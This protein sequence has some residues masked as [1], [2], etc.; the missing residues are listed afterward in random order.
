M[1]KKQFVP[2]PKSAISTFDDGGPRHIR[3]GTVLGYLTVINAHYVEMGIHPPFVAKSKTKTARLLVDT[4]KFELK[5]D[6]R[7]P[8]FDKTF[9]KMHDL[10]RPGPFTGFRSLVYIA[11]LGHYGGFRQQEYTM[12]H[13]NKAKYFVTPAGQ[14]VL[15]FTMEN[16]LFQDKD[17]MIICDALLRPD[18]VEAVGTH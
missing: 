16:I 10:A 14:V 17:R 4:K 12:D 6:R 8:L 18:L 11:A 9:D 2:P 3:S 13:K 7:E 15:A 5:P 1:T